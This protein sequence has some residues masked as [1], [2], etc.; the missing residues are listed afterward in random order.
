MYALRLFQPAQL[1]AVYNM[2]M[3]S[4]RQCAGYHHVRA[5]RAMYNS[6]FAGS[7]KRASLSIV[8]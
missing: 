1:A 5:V 2:R 4:T 3:Y 7:E 8:S 6:R